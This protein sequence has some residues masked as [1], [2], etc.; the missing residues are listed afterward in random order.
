M[1]NEE[2]EAFFHCPDK[3]TKSQGDKRLTWQQLS[4]TSVHLTLLDTTPSTTG[5]PLILPALSLEIIGIARVEM[6]SWLMSLTPWALLVSPVP[7][8]LGIG[9]DRPVLDP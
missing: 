9:S 8:P 1:T 6:S 3:E 7:T 5:H 2:M 4:D